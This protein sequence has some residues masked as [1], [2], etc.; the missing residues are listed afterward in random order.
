MKSEKI[1]N[2]EV[3]EL[4]GSEGGVR[5]EEESQIDDTEKAG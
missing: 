4:W 5:Q 1:D 3:P 2:N